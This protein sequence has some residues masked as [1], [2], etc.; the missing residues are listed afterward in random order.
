LRII[1][2]SIAPVAVPPG[3]RPERRFLYP[4]GANSCHGGMESSAG[5]VLVVNCGSSSLK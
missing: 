2:R 5:T 3:S 1:A 4:A